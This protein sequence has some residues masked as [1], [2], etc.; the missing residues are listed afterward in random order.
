MTL[1]NKLLHKIN[2]IKFL[3]ES[4]NYLINRLSILCY[5]KQMK[6]TRKIIFISINSKESDKYIFKNIPWWKKKIV[7]IMKQYKV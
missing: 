3:C 6:N 5:L 2:Y 1:I 4:C 7:E